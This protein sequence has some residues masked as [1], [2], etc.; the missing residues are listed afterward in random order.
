MTMIEIRNV[1][2]RYGTATVVDNVSMSVE[3]GEITVI[4]GTSGSGKSTLMRMINRLVPI[5]EGEISVGG[6]N[7][8]DVPVTEL[9]RKIGYAIQGHGL[10]PHRT[11]AQ[12]IATVPQL[13]DWDSARIAK[14]VEELLG[15]FNLDPATFADKYPHQLSGGQ[16]QRVGVARALAAEPELLLMDEPF[17]ALD[18]VIRGK[19]QDDLLA[20]QK[21]FGTTVILVTHD[22]DEAFHLGN[23]IAVMSQGRLLQCSTP[24]KIL[25]EP[26]DPF[27][28]QLTGTSDRALKLMSLLP[29]KESMEPAKNGLA[30]ALPQSLSLR[31]ALAEMIWQGVDEAAVQDGEKAPV[32]SIS[33][34]RLLELGRKA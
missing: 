22:M 7:V 17:G 31:D 9:R 13:L 26:A 4:V 6:Q 30:Y 12:N 16:Q 1:T 10:F 14:R 19:A 2:K 18:P 3:K 23:Q 25:T 8:M 15:L 5:T 28:Q 21:Q 33:M 34:T 29:L 24:E 27:V 32:G 20:I 11:V